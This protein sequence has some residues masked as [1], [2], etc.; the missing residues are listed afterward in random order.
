MLISRAMA[1]RPWPWMIVATRRPRADSL[2][3]M[4]GAESSGSTA[5]TLVTVG[6]PP[7]DRGVVGS[8]RRVASR[9]LGSRGEGFFGWMLELGGELPVTHHEDGATEQGCLLD[10]GGD[11]EDGGPPGSQLVGQAVDLRLRP[12]V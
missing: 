3:T 2:R 7:V 10:V 6:G 9:S 4:A 8:V 1:R 12:A 5:L 11:D